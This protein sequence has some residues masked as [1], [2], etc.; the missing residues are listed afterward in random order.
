MIH[1]SK[2]KVLFILL[3]LFIGLNYVNAFDKTAKVYDYAQILTEKEEKKLKTNINEYIE[4]Y[5]MEMVIVTVKHHT[6]N[7]PESYAQEFYKHNEFGKGQ[8]LDGI[9][10]VIDFTSDNFKIQVE[11]FGSATKIYDNNRVKKISQEILSKKE[12]G[13]FKM[14]DLFIKKASEYAKEGITSSNEND[15]EIIINKSILREPSLWLFISIVSFIVSTIIIIILI[16]KNK[17][18]RKS[19]NAKYYL[20]K[21]SV[22]INISKDEFETTETTSDRINHSSKDESK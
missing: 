18:I 9:I 2:L 16:L 17:M 4:K 6:Q 21:D 12:K 7:T 8:N 3:V 20:I 1:K 14:S 19:T 5:N 13:Y 10:F 15:N 22:L 11:P